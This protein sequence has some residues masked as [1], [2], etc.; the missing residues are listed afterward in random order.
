VRWQ[1]DSIDGLN[2]GDSIAPHEHAPA[3]PETCPPEPHPKA[4]R[5]RGRIVE[6]PTLH[7]QKAKGW[8]LITPVGNFQLRVRAGPD[9]NADALEMLDL[10]E[11]K[12]PGTIRASDRTVAPATARKRPTTHYP[13]PT[14]S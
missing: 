2:D 3:N 8:W 6:E 5:S 13:P 10:L 12:D 11:G 1:S 9:T 14:D 7:G 4:S